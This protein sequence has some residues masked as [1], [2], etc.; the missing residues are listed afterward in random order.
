MRNF[1]QLLELASLLSGDMG[2][3]VPEIREKL[4]YFRVG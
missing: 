4:D 1:S 3:T 2:A